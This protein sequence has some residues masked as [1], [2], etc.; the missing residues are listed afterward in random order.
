MVGDRLV[1]SKCKCGAKEQLILCKSRLEH[2]VGD[3]RKRRRCAVNRGKLAA[4]G[5]AA[6][7][8]LSDDLLAA[9]TEA[10]ADMKACAAR[11]I[12][13]ELVAG[14][15]RESE[16]GIVER[17]CA[18]GALRDKVKW[19]TLTAIKSRLSLMRH[20]VRSRQDSLEVAR[21]DMEVYRKVLDEVPAIMV[22]LANGER[23]TL[24]KREELE[25]RAMALS[26][27]MKE[28]DTQIAS[29][30]NSRAQ[31]VGGRKR[32]LEREGKELDQ[33][34]QRLDAM[35]E[36]VGDCQQQRMS[37]SSRLGKEAIEGSGCRVVLEQ[38]NEEE[39]ET[40]TRRVEKLKGELMIRLG[41]KV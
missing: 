17:G 33:L 14:Q 25:R 27:E 36:Y 4:A 8:I 20:R 9:V 10:E 1:D 29:V 22:D 5:Q 28:I 13:E 23:E 34:A 7:R 26:E 12:Q 3:D 19:A 24:Q 21:S 6:L 35:Q 38:I 31:E 40:L 30:T 2:L 37:G 39:L 32:C 15:L 16:I 41:S 18:L 11:I